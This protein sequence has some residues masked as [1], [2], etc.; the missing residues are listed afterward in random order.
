MTKEIEEENENSEQNG[1]EKENENENGNEFNIINKKEDLQEE[2]EEQEE[3]EEED[4][5][6]N[7]KEGQSNNEK[8]NEEEEEQE[9]E[10][11]EEIE[12]KIPK[13]NSNNEIQQE[14]I[15]IQNEIKNEEI[16]YSS[17]EDDE[18]QELSTEEE[19]YKDKNEE[20]K[21]T[22]ISNNISEG[23]KIV[24]Q[25]AKRKPLKIEIYSN[26]I[27]KMVD[28][29]NKRKNRI[30]D[31]EKN[32]ITIHNNNLNEYMKELEDKIILMKKGYIETLVEKHFENNP[33]NK[34]E[35]ILKANIPKKRNDVKKIFKKLMGYI[36][37]KLQAPNQKYYYIL[38]L[39]ILNKYKNI[40]NDEIKEEKK[41]F[42]KK[43]LNGK[44]KNEGKDD[45][46][47][48]YDD[49]NWIRQQNSKRNVSFYLFSIL[50]PLA[51]IINYIYAYG[52]A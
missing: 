33:N 10:E 11:V 42:N 35:I 15:D 44:I 51:Y 3:I 24:I 21:E 36:K 23:N 25:Y 32:E 49:Y 16:G 1:N 48:N 22:K 39:K 13:K 34:K 41:L 9:Q 37:E 6:K 2:Q 4:K 47:Y 50:I 19:E 20:S 12:I 46:K 30:N 52:K 17:E 27:Q 8:E 29:T 38:I 7:I 18:E 26:L 40:N 31:K 28:I 14:T 5:E 43:K 45:I